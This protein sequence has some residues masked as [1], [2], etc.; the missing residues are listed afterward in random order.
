VSVI[1]YTTDD[2][3]GSL[4]IADPLLDDIDR[5]GITLAGL[6]PRQLSSRVR[7]EAAATGP[8]R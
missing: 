3:R 1:D 7:T 8:E 5:D 2:W 6:T 4:E